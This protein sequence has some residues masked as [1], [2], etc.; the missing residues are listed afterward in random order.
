[1][2][3]FLSLVL[4]LVMTM[5]LVTISAGAKEFTDDDKITYEEAV[6]VIS[7]IGVVD[8]DTNGAF[9][10]TDT[11]TRQAAAKI[12]CNLILGPTTAA[13]LH[14][15]T[16]PYRDVPTGN[17]FAGYI[18]YCQQR[19][20]ISGYSDGTFRPTGTLTGY[21]FMKMLL[22]ALGY[23][24]NL[25][26]YVGDN[27]S[28]NVAKQ[29]LGIKLTKGLEGE[30]N[31]L[32]A[33]SREEACLYAFRTIQADLVEYGQRVSTIVNGQEIILSTGGAK[34]RTWGSQATKYDHI[35]NDGLVQFA[36]EYFNKLE[37]KV[38]EDEFERP[39]YTWIYD[40][41]EIGT[42]VDWELMVAEYDDAVTGREL[43]DVISSA[44]L[45]D[46]DM[47]LTYYVNG[48]EPVAGC[49]L[50]N[51][52]LD[53]V[54]TPY[55]GEGNITKTNGVLQRSNQNDAGFSAR[56]VLTQVFIDKDVREEIIITSIDTWLSKATTDYNEN[57][58]TVPMDVW[59]SESHSPNMNWNVDVE[60]VP[61]IADVKEDQFYLMQISYKD[62]TNGDVISIWEPEVLEDAE[63]SKFSTKQNEV[64][65]KVTT[66]GTEYKQ[67]QRGY[68]D[69]AALYDYDETLL[70]DRKYNIFLD[71][72]GN[73]IGIELS[74]GDAKYV[75]IA[76]FDRPRSNLTVQT[77]NA[78][79]IFLDGTMQVIK[80]NVTDTDK[81]IR[82][83]RNGTDQAKEYFIEWQWITQAVN[84]DGF[85]ALN[86]WFTYSVNESGVY[87]LKPATRMVAY[88]NSAD[89]TIKTSN[90]Y[91]DDNVMDP[92]K[93]PYQGVR[94]QGVPGGYTNQM[95]PG[96]ARY[97]NLNSTGARAYGNDDSVY[98]TVETDNVDTWNTVPGSISGVTGVYTG[99]QNVEIELDISDIQADRPIDE[100][101]IY[102][103]YDSDNYI[104][105]AVTVGEGKGNNA[106]IAYITS[107]VK[108]E[109]LE[110]DT[111]YWE[112]DA[113]VNGTEQT[114]TAR[115]KFGSIFT[116][117]IT[118]EA[119][120]IYKG[121][122]TPNDSTNWNAYD[123]LVELRFDADD[124]VVSAKPVLE[125][126]IYSYVGD[127][128][129]GAASPK[130]KGNYSEVS[131][132]GDDW[133]TL[134]V[135]ASRLD[136]KDAKAYRVNVITE[137]V[138]ATPANKVW[139]DSGKF[140]HYDSAP[141][142][143]TLV[144]RT[145]Y[146][147]SN[148]N[149]EGLALASDAK[150]VVIQRENGKWK[151]REFGSVR[152]GLSQIVDANYNIP[153]LQFHGQI[154]AVMKN[155]TA[156]WVLFISDQNLVSGGGGW[157]PGYGL[158]SVAVSSVTGA[159]GAKTVNYVLTGTNDKQSYRVSLEWFSY[160]GQWTEVSSWN[161]K[162]ALTGLTP[163]TS[164]IGGVN[165]TSESQYVGGLM[166]G[167]TYR[168]AC[169]NY[170]SAPFLG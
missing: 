47:D 59:T 49:D 54:A 67:A 84:Q 64:P 101:Y 149:D 5:S 107:D 167:Q 17:Q 53:V 57:K 55:S 85:H 120:E 123:G 32:K 37:K 20:I 147:T 66:S 75:F 95:A 33:V 79:A 157:T 90:L 128:S 153:G 125:K 112:F 2:K 65:S 110:G 166:A 58:E 45:K 74:E 51:Y 111:Y 105:G 156:A 160:T 136:L 102:A 126:D 104:V 69:P 116:N 137:D 11:L 6:D 61:E 9:R 35:R 121:V 145:L 141:N 97:S 29:A 22:G 4:A 100:A 81:R 21:A 13:E 130:F 106:T 71:Q 103:V 132:T 113:I 39:A 109:R 14:A 164:V 148:Q 118:N 108:S 87:T 154:V 73:M 150:S 133:G 63:I 23:D 30:F 89:E 24:S 27:W 34:S 83:V 129:A 140:Y 25:E 161:V 12:I 88:K 78:S 158:S 18:A 40:K 68:Y 19:G 99:V 169:E 38:G 52:V 76:G 168:L 62:N 114:L 46:E 7:T 91:L 36:E 134:P 56:G 92:A 146:I 48:V 1:M 115:S 124:Y 144:S 127:K 26:G 31:G 122:S 119:S 96:G 163:N 139:S 8:G 82:D 10:P 93:Y 42:Y 77:A 170:V 138:L 155:G 41:E 60:D 162:A 72:F 117:V 152:A 28:I 165:V 16:A 43:Y 80:V 70:T 135:G 131:A 143:L 44:V 98:I 151:T 50:P 142:E 94:S 86:R 159:P 15:D 3:K